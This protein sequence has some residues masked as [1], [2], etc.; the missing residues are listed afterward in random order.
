MGPTP[1]ASNVIKRQGTNQI[2][3]QGARSPPI[4]LG[5]EVAKTLGGLSK[6]ENP[7]LVWTKYGQAMLH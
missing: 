2:E 1:G 7:Q 3:F 5:L 6:A 4:F